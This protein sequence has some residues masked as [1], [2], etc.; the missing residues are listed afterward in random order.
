[1]NPW[2]NWF[3]CTGNT[4]GTWLPGDP[5]GWRSWKHREHVDGDYKHPP[6][7]GKYDRLLEHSQKLMKRQRVVL[8]IP[9]RKLACRTM[10]AAL[11]FHAVDLIALAV[12]PKHFHMLARFAPNPEHPLPTQ[13]PIPGINTSAPPS[14]IR[15]PRH[16]VGIAKKESARALSKAGLLPEGGAWGKRCRP[17]PIRDRAH[18]LRVVGYIKDHVEEGAVVWFLGGTLMPHTGASKSRRIAIRRRV[19]KTTSS[20][21]I[22]PTD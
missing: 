18:Q 2:H 3:H 15:T 13:C 17:R 4:Y 21:P 5:R 7:A 8:E 14:R 1:M 6:P 22:K 9:Q 11:R 16:L 20:P 12:G 10:V 19:N